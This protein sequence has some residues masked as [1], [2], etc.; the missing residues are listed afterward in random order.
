[1]VACILYDIA[2][3]LH[4]LHKQQ[5]CHRNI[6][7]E[8]IY[9]DIDEGISLLS[10]FGLMKGIRWKDAKDRRNTMVTPEREPFTDPLILF[11]DDN[12]SW[13]AGD[14]YAFGISALQITYGSTPPLNAKNILHKQAQSISTDLYD[15][16]C[17]FGKSF[18]NLIKECCNPNVEQRIKISKLMEH[19][20]FRSKCEPTHVKQYFSHI[21]KSTEKRINSSLQ[22]PLSFN[23]NGTISNNNDE[24]KNDINAIQQIIQISPSQP[25]GGNGYRVNI[26]TQNGRHQHMNGKTNIDANGNMQTQHDPEWSFSTSLRKSEID[27]KIQNELANGNPSVVNEDMS[28][29]DQ[30]S[31]SGMYHICY[32]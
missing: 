27:M 22:A 12:A 2:N 9:V 10:E 29:D 16:K 4:N 32:S 30:P 11:G 13:Y 26:E 5:Q 31:H 6:R 17:P 14:I 21:L 18:E 23:Y 7:A 24:N 28:T 20:F 19:K 25:N 3:G 1:M 15:K 8:S